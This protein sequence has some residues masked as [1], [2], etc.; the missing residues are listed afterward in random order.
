MANQP[1]LSRIGQPWVYSVETRRSKKSEDQLTTA[2]QHRTA[3]S[4]ERVLVQFHWTRQGCRDSGT[5]AQANWFNNKILSHED[6][7]IAQSPW[8]W[9]VDLAVSRL[10]AVSIFAVLLWWKAWALKSRDH[11]PTARVDIARLDTRH[12]IKQWCHCPLAVRIP[13][14]AY[15]RSRGFG[16]QRVTSPRSWELVFPSPPVRLC[17]LQCRVWISLVSFSLT[18]KDSN[19]TS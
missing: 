6:T 5:Q 1:L 18:R 10:E 19:V 9:R 12:Q 13:T 17:R 11:R 15:Y 7:G 4:V 16:L 14:A 8:T 3:L 2:E